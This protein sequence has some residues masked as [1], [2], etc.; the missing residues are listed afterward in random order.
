MAEEKEKQVPKKWMEQLQILLTKRK[1]LAF[2]L[3]EALE[4]ER[5][6]IT[7]TA[8]KI[9]DPQHPEM[10]LQHFWDQNKFENNDVL[11]SIQH[12]I[13]N[14]TAIKNPNAEIPKDDKWH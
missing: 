2:K 11:N 7:I 3:F 9:A 4:C 13:A 5:F 1:A 8:Q 12:I 6:F 14:W 10:D